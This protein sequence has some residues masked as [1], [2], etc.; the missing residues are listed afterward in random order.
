MTFDRSAGTPLLRT[1][2]RG[3]RSPVRSPPR[4]DNTVITATGIE[5]RAG[6]RILVEGA[7]FRVAPG[8]KVGLVGRNGAGKTTL[9]KALA[10]ETE[11]H[12]GSITRSGE[13][14]YL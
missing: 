6:S 4:I 12:G 5:L 7:T 11:P 9:T 3:G 10:G 13:V 1:G 8:D 2:E 14:G